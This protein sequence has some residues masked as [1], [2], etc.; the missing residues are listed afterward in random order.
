MKGNFIAD[1]TFPLP[2]Q[3][4]CGAL[5]VPFFSIGLWRDLVKRRELMLGTCT[6]T[7]PVK[8]SHT[9]NQVK[10]SAA[11]ILLVAPLALLGDYF[12]FYQARPFITSL[13]VG[14]MLGCIYPKQR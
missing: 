14:L 10:V 11:P 3:S 1:H 12:K 7:L 4:I 9:M 8:F 2:Q 5:T 6:A 13:T